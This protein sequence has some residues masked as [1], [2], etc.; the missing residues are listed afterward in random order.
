MPAHATAPTILLLNK[1]KYLSPGHR[2]VFLPPRRAELGLIAT[3]LNIGSERHSICQTE[4]I[5]EGH[6]EWTP[7]GDYFPPSLLR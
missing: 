7:K 4:E 3:A 5:L 2:F 6:R 1:A